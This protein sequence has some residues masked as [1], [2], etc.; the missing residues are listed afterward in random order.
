MFE[1]PFIFN[2][3]LGCQ[4]CLQKLNTEAPTSHDIAAQIISAALLPLFLFA[5]PSSVI[6]RMR[7][8]L[9]F[10]SHRVLAILG[11]LFPS[12]EPLLKNTLLQHLF[13]KSQG[14]FAPAL[15][16]VHGGIS[17]VQGGR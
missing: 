17:G 1:F 6:S 10:E 9:L 13:S 14:L 7:F 5:A 2:S 15:F 3:I 8:S 11:R 16:T 4:T 12:P